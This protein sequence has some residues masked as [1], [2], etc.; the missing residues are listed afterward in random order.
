MDCTAR[1]TIALPLSASETLKSSKKQLV[2]SKAQRNRNVGVVLQDSEGS[3]STMIIGPISTAVWNKYWDRSDTAVC[4]LAPTLPKIAAALQPCRGE[5]S[6]LGWLV[7][8][9]HPLSHLCFQ[10][11]THQGLPTK[12]LVIEASHGANLGVDHVQHVLDS[13][14][15]PAST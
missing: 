1:H 15:G 4:P 13:S 11:F 14:D 2:S 7:Q 6:N 3:V 10:H 5:N 9:F 8:C 12:A